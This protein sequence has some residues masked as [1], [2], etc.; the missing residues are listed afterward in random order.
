MGKCGFIRLNGIFSRKAK[1]FF[2]VF[3]VK[4]KHF[5]LL[6]AFKKLSDHQNT[7]WN[8]KS[9]SKWIKPF[10]SI[11]VS[12]MKTAL[13]MIELFCLFLISQKLPTNFWKDFFIPWTILIAEK[14]Q[15]TTNNLLCLL[16]CLVVK[17][18][19]SMESVKIKLISWF[20]YLCFEV[21]I[22]MNELKMLRISILSGK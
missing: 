1:F 9:F 12:K 14:Q 18:V 8:L 19:C 13:G 20:D 3:T 10:C 16:A 22:L 11:Q 21:Y 15:R 2:L 6:R 5:K 4:K 17:R 7:N